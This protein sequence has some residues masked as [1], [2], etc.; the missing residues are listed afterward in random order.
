M[1]LTPAKK[2]VLK[3]ALFPVALTVFICFIFGSIFYLI[4]L[5]L[6]FYDYAAMLALLSASL[7]GI[8]R[9]VDAHRRVA[10]LAAFRSAPETVRTLRHLDPVLH[11]ALIDHVA[12]SEQEKTALLATHRELLDTLGVWVHQMKTP[13]SAADLA[14]QHPEHAPETV[15]PPILA[16]MY[17]YVDMAIACI[18]LAEDEPFL[19]LAT[20]DVESVLTRSLQKA[21][22]L[23]VYAQIK[24]N[25]HPVSLQA[26]SDS[27]WLALIF[28]QILSNAVKYA[29]GGTVTIDAVGESIRI[30]DNGMGIP[31]DEL[32][33]V[34]ER[35]FAGTRGRLDS[36]ASGLGLYLAKRISDRLG[37][38][39][40][41]ESSLGE[42]TLVSI[43]LA[44][45]D[46][47]DEMALR[48]NGAHLTKM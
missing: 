20:V 6:L 7:V 5:P 10:D 47:M 38:R 39:I 2:T 30:R 22:T 37:H 4:R 34:F 45:A 17:G 48:Q 28:D 26:V 16:Q 9:G 24:L 19:D 15:L 25:Y 41:I 14:L 32:P 29:P 1:A 3:A 43:H 13:L 8:K 44:R 11:D 40:T 23:F 33:R 36:R 21:A 31:S 46:L 35:G 42:G 27:R 18:E 12:A